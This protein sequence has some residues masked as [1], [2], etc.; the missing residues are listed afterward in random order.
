MWSSRLAISVISELPI[1][2]DNI[3][4]LAAEHGS[5]VEACAD[6]TAVL[7]ITIPAASGKATEPY[8]IRLVSEG[9]HIEAF[10]EPPRR[11]PAAC[12][13]RHIKFDGS[14]CLFWGLV[15][16]IDP[17][18]MP[19]AREWWRHLIGFLRNQRIAHRQRRWPGKFHARAHGQEAAMHQTRA[20]I[21]A[22]VIGRDFLAAM[23]DGAFSI[24]RNNQRLRLMLDD[25]RIADVDM[26]AEGSRVEVART[27]RTD[28]ARTFRIIHECYLRL[29]AVAHFTV[30][31]FQ[32]EAA[33]KMFWQMVWKEDPTCCGTMDGC[34]LA[35]ETRENR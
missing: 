21:A 25:H 16:R 28:D 6:G 24:R 18:T 13:E 32:R 5:V 19:G 10:E 30:A 29:T 35:P 3:C 26:S 1:A 27:H 2:L 17:R 8:K 23:K 20:E 15:D 34:P 9:D 4:A 31:M 22:E 33:E 11:L 14:F 12:F 7:T